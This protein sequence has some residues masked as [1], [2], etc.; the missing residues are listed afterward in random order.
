MRW[1]IKTP[2]WLLSLWILL[3]FS[4]GF[5]ISRALPYLGEPMAKQEALEF[6]DW[7]IGQHQHYINRPDLCNDWTG[8]PE[9]NK[10]LVEKYKGIIALIESK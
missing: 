10:E 2:I 7:C 3:A 4:S 9:R 5:C 6:A 8:T 1:A